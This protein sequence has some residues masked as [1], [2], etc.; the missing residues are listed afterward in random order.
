MEATQK[1]TTFISVIPRLETGTVSVV[2]ATATQLIYWNDCVQQKSSISQSIEGLLGQVYFAGEEDI[3][4]AATAAAAVRITAMAARQCADDSPYKCE[5]V[6][7]MEDSSLLYVRFG[8]GGV[9]IS[10]MERPT[11]TNVGVVDGIRA[12][13][14]INM[15]T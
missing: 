4:L 9:S 10:L 15:P 12:V 8:S 6:L 14:G 2:V 5:A 11:G 1:E 3:N 7:G 13:A